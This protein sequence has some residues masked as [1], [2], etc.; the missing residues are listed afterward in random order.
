MTFITFHYKGCRHYQSRQRPRQK[1]G[2]GLTRVRPERPPPPAVGTKRA[3]TGRLQHQC[4]CWEGR[5]SLE[6]G[7]QAGQGPGLQG[8]HIS[9]VL[10]SSWKG[11]GSF[12]WRG[13]AGSV[14]LSC[15]SSL[16]VWCDATAVSTCPQL[17]GGQK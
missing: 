1:D 4:T 17:A 8:L 9:V 7:T 2:Q 6:R 14:D 13:V 16:P 15:Q 5:A 12:L 10:P 11:K 3:A